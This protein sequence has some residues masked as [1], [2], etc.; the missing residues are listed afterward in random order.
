MRKSVLVCSPPPTN[1]GI[2]RQSL[3]KIYASENPFTR[4]HHRLPQ[5]I[6]SL[7]HGQHVS[8]QAVAQ[9]LPH[10]LRPRVS[11][12]SWLQSVRLRLKL[13]YLLKR[14]R[15]S[16]EKAGRVHFESSG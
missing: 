15:E 11:L 4:T 5:R 12:G 10:G 7:D 8:I 14:Q 1:L 16:P 6:A 2:Q 3:E 13:R 9:R